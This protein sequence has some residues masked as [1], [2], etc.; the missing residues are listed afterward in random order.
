[1]VD[2][3]RNLWCAG[4]VNY[5]LFYLIP[6]FINNCPSGGGGYHPPINNFPGGG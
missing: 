2:R 3:Q 4:C 1:M 6:G 5:Y